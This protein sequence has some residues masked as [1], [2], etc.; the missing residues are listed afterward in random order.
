MSA[1]TAGGGLLVAAVLLP[2]CG[3]MAGFVLG[4]RA[5]ERI[6]LLLV[7]V[8]IGL[9]VAIVAAVIV[10]QAPVAY[11]LGGFAPPLGLVLRADGAGAAMLL[12]TALILGVVAAYARPDF[13]APAD[14]ASG[15]R[16]LSFWTL[17]LALSASLNL[18][19]LAGDLF[20]LFVA[21][22]MLTVAAVP[23]VCLD[24]RASQV[25]AALRYLVFALLGSVL[26]LLGVGL[27]YGAHGTLDIGLLG[28]RAR[29]D[30]PAIA[31]LALMTAGL[32]AKTAMLPLH[33]WLPPAH[34][35][36]PPPASALLSA[37][38]VK[39]SYLI[40]VRLWFQALPEVP[41]V[42]AA[43]VM[44]AMGAAAILL[45]SVMALRQTRLKL[46]VA[47]STVAQIGYLGFVFPL[48]L[49]AAPGSEG[50]AWTG[51][52]LQMIAHAFAKAA[53]FL[54]AGLIAEA[55]GHDRIAR[56][57]GIARTMPVT[58]AAFGLSGLS[59]M[60]LPPSGGF[61]AKWLLLYVSVESGQWWWS[62]AI[63]GG[64]LLTAGYVFRVL[65]AARGVAGAAPP[66][67]CGARWR[68]G[69]VMGLACVSVAIGLLP[70]GSFGIL[71]IGA[72][73]P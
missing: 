24:G 53:M 13:G 11:V 37:L 22:E 52:M 8:G 23:M 49:G 54:S 30:A 15:R 51:G 21:L 25:E 56:L 36:A 18:A 39:G 7:A 12:T 29:P 35:G 48:G 9:A 67:L 2:V 46:L 20:N 14:A 17:L 5:A 19:F 44:G 47:Y 1:G 73:L 61:A 26:Y 55:C 31:A 59:L 10:A 60:G 28:P 69:L 33:L 64:G 38:V 43:Q 41:T 68:E 65:S 70:I 62:V 34:A 45:G 66:V 72:P 32:L 4:A 58:L 50:Y 3:L 42:A 71:R 57:G 16:A 6:A 40:V 63:L 27:L